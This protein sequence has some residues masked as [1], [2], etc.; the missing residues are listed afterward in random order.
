MMSF[1]AAGSLLGAVAATR[2]HR[3]VAP[4]VIVAGYPWLGAVAL[5]ALPAHPFALG[6][7]FG[8]WV[9]FGSDVGRRRGRPSHP[10][11]PRRLQ[12]RVESVGSLVAFGGAALGPLVGG[13]VASRLTG[14]RGVPVRRGDRHRRRARRS[15]RRVARA[16]FRR[17]RGAGVILRNRGLLA[18]LVAEVVSRVGSQMTFLALPWFVL[19]TT[20]SPAKMGIV[21]AVELAPVGAARHP[22]RDGRLALRR[23]ADDARRG[24]RP[25]AADG[26]AADP[27]LRPG[28][29]SFPLLLVLVAAFGCFSAPYFASQRRDP[30]GAARQRR[31]ESSPRRTASSR[32]RRRRAALLGPPLAGVLIAAFGAANVLYVDA[33]TFAFSFSPCCCSSRAQAAA[34]PEESAAC[35]PG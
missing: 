34:S 18:L 12:G 26:V 22:E 32:A 24:P 35:W 11:R 19:V 29:L 13:L 3:F 10:Y 7:I 27:A 20:D 15:G 31:A 28:L 16:A 30:A 8:V 14:A 33:A 4:R 5:L 17:R 9:F 21:L 25:R 23:A 6:A 2:L 1:A